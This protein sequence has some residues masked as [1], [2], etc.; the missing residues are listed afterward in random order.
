MNK[1]ELIKT[2]GLQGKITERHA[3]QIEEILKKH[4]KAFQEE[5][6]EKMI[7]NIIKYIKDL[8]DWKNENIVRMDSGMNCAKKIIVSKLEVFKLDL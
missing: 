2:F 6:E 8:P 5:T 7:D 3:L 1:K 4:F